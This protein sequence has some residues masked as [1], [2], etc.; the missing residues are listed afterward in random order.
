MAAGKP[1]EGGVAGSLSL[2]R[3]WL[4][5]GRLYFARLLGQ[6]VGTVLTIFSARVLA[7]E[8]RGDF[9]SVSAVAVIGAQALNLGLSSSLVVLFSRRPL[10]IGRHRRQLLYL[11]LLWVAFLTALGALQAGL[12]SPNTLPWW[13]FWAIWIPLQLLCLYQG[14]AMLALQ[15]AKALSRIEL[16]GRCAALVL[17]GGSLLAFG[18]QL[19]PFLAAIIAADGLIAALGALHLARVAPGTPVRAERAAHFF[20]SALRMGLRA[21]PPLVLLF[22]L[23]KS[24]ILV[25]RLLRGAAET[26]IYSIAS[27]IVDIAL[28]LPSTIGALVL[29]SV[30]RAPRPAAELVRVLRPTAFL[31]GGLAL[32]MLVLGHWAI[33]LLFGHPF[34][35][36]Y[37]ALVL[38]LPGF[39]CL[40][41]QSLLGQYFAS[42]GFPLFISLYWLAGFVVNLA[43][44]LLFVPRFGLLAAAVSSSVSYGFVFLLML[45]R[46]RADRAAEA[47]W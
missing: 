1:L 44:N 24:D 14:A 30:V 5:Y 2:G 12:R 45:R 3:E 10:R 34:E 37:R 47:S 21:Y 31:V 20:G 28:I 26:G 40:A 41:L 19:R 9:V 7:P 6:A 27:Q 18:S 35:G 13:P 46:F 29:A 42:R 43:L 36:A 39:V 8:G 38:L 4:A 23:V 17:G 33:V 25:L 11:A 15:D 32:A 22:L 16:A